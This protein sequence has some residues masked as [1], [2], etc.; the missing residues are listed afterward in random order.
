[1]K[2]VVS[3]YLFF[4]CKLTGDNIFLYFPFIYS[5]ELRLRV[6]LAEDG[7]LTLISR[8][9]N[10]NCR[11]FNFSIAFHTYLSVSDI[12]YENIQ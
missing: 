8:I 5:F 10:I 12:G 7:R 1:M 3:I 9:R 6:L 2:E 4:L 11:P